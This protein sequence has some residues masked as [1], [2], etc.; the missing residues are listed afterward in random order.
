M[1]MLVLIKELKANFDDI[2]VFIVA[3]SFVL[4]GLHKTKG[5]QIPAKKY[6]FFY[7]H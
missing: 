5:I 6:S 7:Y 3:I 1:S 2:D 4:P